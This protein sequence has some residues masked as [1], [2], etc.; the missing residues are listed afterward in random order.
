M[1][2][3]SLW[4]CWHLSACSKWLYLPA[5]VC[6]FWRSWSFALLF[7][8]MLILVCSGFHPQLRFSHKLRIWKGIHSCM[9][10]HSYF[11]DNFFTAKP[12]LGADLLPWEIIPNLEDHVY[13]HSIHKTFLSL[14]YMTIFHVQT[15]MHNQWVFWLWLHGTSTFTSFSQRDYNAIT[16]SGRS[17]RSWPTI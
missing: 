16:I 3:L 14:N 10:H 7:F 5:P 12:E 11:S 2:C 15:F 9:S 4:P 6:K 8:A 13:S 17:Q 1:P